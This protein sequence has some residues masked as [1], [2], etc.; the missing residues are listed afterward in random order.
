MATAYL[1][2]IT[3]PIKPHL[4]NYL[5][6]EKNLQG[7]IYKKF[8]REDLTSCEMGMV[9]SVDD[10]ILYHEFLHYMNEELLIKNRELSSSPDFK[11]EDFSAVENKYMDLF[12][13]LVSSLM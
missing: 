5:H 9:S 8:L 2:D 11:F 13:S 10:A 3:R 1:A 6:I 7:A 4:N 12:N